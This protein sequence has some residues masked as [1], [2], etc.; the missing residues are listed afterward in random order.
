M[1]DALRNALECN[2]VIAEGAGQLERAARVKA[3]L[4]E[5]DKPSAVTEGLGD[6]ATREPALTD[7][8]KAELRDLA[9]QRGIEV[10]DS[11]LKAELVEALEPKEESDGDHDQA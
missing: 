9:D 3:R 2:L 6:P 10:D 7:L 8:T 5:L 4:A 1:A 11:M